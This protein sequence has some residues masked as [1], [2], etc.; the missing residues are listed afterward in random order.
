MIKIYKIKHNTDLTRE[1]LLARKV[2]QFAIDNRDKLSTKYVRHLG[3]ASAISNQVLRKYGRNK[4]AKAIH[5]V[6]LTI[7]GCKTTLKEN[8]LWI[9][10]L[11]L[12]ISLDRPLK[13]RQ[14]QL[15]KQYAY[16]AY[17]VE[18]LPQY[19]PE[20]HIGIDLNT[21]SHCAVMAIK[22]TGKVYKLGKKAEYIH[23]KYS[24]MRKR[25]QR[26][27]KFLALAKIKHRE[28]NIIRDLNHKISRK[29]INLAV[30]KKGGVQLEKLQGI[31]KYRIKSKTFKYSLNSWS[32]YQ[33]GKFIEY[34]ALLAGVPV[35]Y[36]DPA[37]TSKACS[38]CGLI[39]ERNRKYFKCP[40]GHVENA[41][42]NAAFNLCILSDSILKLQ[43][44]R[45]A[46]KGGTATPQ[47][48]RAIKLVN[49][50]VL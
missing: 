45:D 42:V 11:K 1:L 3:L 48:D 29:I 15:D 24:H 14:V 13:V 40:T 43:A 44:D 50:K 46:R 18:S 27:G 26:K 20:S 49:P 10:C 36:V 33:L 12:S 21:T 19:K 5:S 4:K 38:R 41:D 32:Y 22:E 7:A 8:V 16:I 23:K 9:P 30:E 35:T 47:R 39:G 37:Y 28:A 34:K 6:S 31:R 25:L 2:A 17:K